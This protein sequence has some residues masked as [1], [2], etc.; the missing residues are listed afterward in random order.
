MKS[1]NIKDI[2][3]L[4]ENTPTSNLS[5]NIL[6][7][8]DTISGT[9]FSLKS[10]KSEKS[11]D[12]ISTMLNNINTPQSPDKKGFHRINSFSNESKNPIT[13][14]ILKYNK[15]DYAI[16][17]TKR[18]SILD[19]NQYKN[20]VLDIPNITSSSPLLNNNNNTNPFSRTASNEYNEY[21]V[22]YNIDD[23]DEEYDKKDPLI[24]KIF[25]YKEKLDKNLFILSVKYDR[26]CYKYNTISL[27]IMI[28]ST[29]STFIE[30]ARL[31]LTEYLR[32]NENTLSIDTD[33]FT[34]SINILMLV[35]GTVITILSSI[36]RFKNYRETMEKLKNYQNIIVKYKILYD[37][38]IDIIKIFKCNN[39]ELDDE[40]FKE[41]NNKL[42]EYNK[43]V[44]ENINLVEDIR[45]DDKVK[46]Q[47]F[48]HTFDIK[49]EKMKQ[50]RNI[51]LLKNKN[52]AEI[53]KSMLNDEKELEMIKLKVIKNKN[54]LKYEKYNI[55]NDK[56]NGI[57]ISRRPNKKEG[58]VVT[59]SN[60]DIVSTV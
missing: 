18:A 58:T 36:V 43:E 35:L 10:E 1:F 3:K 57:D 48:K 55:F 6:N 50:Q 42:R 56:D 45:N 31:T 60:F 30:A 24:R 47:Q 5:I 8:E 22:K 32:N 41:L 25:K 59:M 39:R 33:I 14:P 38:Q 28:L 23:D 44:N 11:S 15:P 2:S 9:S 19:N 21:N 49:L 20:P 34:L 16:M 17:T 37:K 53:K 52:N 46:L 4:L 29:I 12:N 51:E 7:E 27:T 54:N 13:T 40:T 26:I